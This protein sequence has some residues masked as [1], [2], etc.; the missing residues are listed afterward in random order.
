MAKP[1][2]ETADILVMLLL[3]CMDVVL[4]LVTL[5]ERHVEPVNRFCVEVRLDHK[6][7]DDTRNVFFYCSLY[8]L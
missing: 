7:R 1:L 3:K 5:A 2:P 8:M 4:H 6:Q